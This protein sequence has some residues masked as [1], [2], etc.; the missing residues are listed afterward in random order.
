MSSVLHVVV[1]R[2]EELC[3]KVVYIYDYCNYSFLSTSTD[4]ISP[5]AREG[6][7]WENLS[8]IQSIVYCFGCEGGEGGL[9]REKG[10]G[11]GGT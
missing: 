6:T 11:E 1:T 8:V 4:N 5:K 10:V 9:I 7:V 2:G 3:G